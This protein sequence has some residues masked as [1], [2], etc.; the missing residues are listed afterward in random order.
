MESFL[1]QA[2]TC[3]QPLRG[4]LSGSIMPSAKYKTWKSPEQVMP[5]DKWCPRR[6]TW[7]HMSSCKGQELMSWRSVASH[8]KAFLGLVGFL[9]WRQLSEERRAGPFL[10]VIHYFFAIQP[11]VN[12]WLSCSLIKGLLSCNPC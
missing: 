4:A 6:T 9:L 1:R 10:L 8:P 3:I 5:P 11:Y 2:F 12:R 7:R